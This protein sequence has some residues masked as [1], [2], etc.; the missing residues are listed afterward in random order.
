MIYKFANCAL[1]C[2]LR[3]LTVDGMAVHL[4]P[5]VFDLLRHLIENRNTVVSRD[6][7]IEAVWL[8]RTVSETTISARIWA[9]RHA[10]GDTGE[11]QAVIR[12][13]PR[14][15]FHFAAPVSEFE[16]RSEVGL[17]L[18]DDSEF[19]GDHGRS[20][21]DRPPQSRRA[22]YIR[23]V[24]PFGHFR[25][26]FALAAASIM[27]LG[28]GAGLVSLE[29]PW[30]ARLQ[31]AS[32]ERMAF[33]LPDR[34]SIAVLPFANLSIDAAQHFMGEGLTESLVNALAVNPLL[35]VTSQSSTSLYRDRSV[36]AH[37]AA[38]E[39]GVRYVLEGSVKQLDGQGRYP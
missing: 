19:Q 31:T 9:A 12:T 11:A 37:Q 38:E 36:A 23:Y 14:R 15:G 8:G 25:V 7:L 1:D 18:R 4:E 39:L 13:V 20:E 30:D 24:R 16:S 28:F 2:S 6:D 33:P 5:Q 35:F 27:L 34:P 10:V 26:R 17:S 3:Q 22:A 32:V 21:L 29:R